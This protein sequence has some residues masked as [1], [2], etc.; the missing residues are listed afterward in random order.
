MVTQ[1]QKEI[2][3]IVGYGNS[4]YA[5]CVLCADEL[6]ATDTIIYRQDCFDTPPICDVCR[7]PLAVVR[8]GH[9]NIDDNI[10]RC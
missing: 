8:I 1:K 4:Y 3:D 9:K 5:V 2:D 7:E 6:D 10:Y